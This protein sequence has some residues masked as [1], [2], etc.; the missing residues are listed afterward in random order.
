MEL[1]GKKTDCCYSERHAKH[2]IP[3]TTVLNQ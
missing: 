3:R 1:L 2:Y